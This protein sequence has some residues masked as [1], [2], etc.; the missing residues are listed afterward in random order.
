MSNSE[1]R[2]VSLVIL[3]AGNSSRMGRPKQAL[4]WMGKPLLTWQTEECGRTQADELIV[5]LGEDADHHQTL[6]PET[7]GRVPAY[8]VIRNPHSEQ[9]KTTSVLAGLNASDWRATEW[10]FLAMDSPRPAHLTDALIEAH[11]AAGLPI[12][13]PWHGGIEG[14]PPVMN[15]SLRAEIEVITEEKRGLREV[16]ERDPARVNRVE[17]ADPTVIINLNSPEDYERALTLTGQTQSVRR[18]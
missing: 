8:R 10:V 15:S 6:L 9:G 2:F 3:A 16:T 18:E 4:S 5:V 17:F 13:Y 7:V 11:F 1:N 14:H 12:S